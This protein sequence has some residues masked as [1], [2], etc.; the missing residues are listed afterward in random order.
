MTGMVHPSRAIGSGGLEVW[1]LINEGR[2]RL[3][4]RGISGHN[5]RQV[6]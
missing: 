3:R 6:W 4:G 2:E 5:E 1:D